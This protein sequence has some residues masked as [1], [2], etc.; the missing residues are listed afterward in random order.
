[1]AEV[2]YPFDTGGAVLEDQWRKM[3]RLWA[4][5]GVAADVDDQLEVF[6]DA[7]GLTVKVRTGS[8]WV[9]GHLFENTTQLTLNQP[10]GSPPHATL[11]RRD[12]IVLRADYVANGILVTWK[13]GVAAPTPVPPTLQQDSSVWEISLAVVAVAAAAPNIASGDFID[14]RTFS[15]RTGN[16]PVGIPVPQLHA[17]METG[18]VLADGRT[19]ANR[20]QFARLFAVWG[21]TFGAGD[22]VTTFG[23]PDLRG[24]TIVGL[25][26]MGGA[27]AG[28]LSVA[29]TI[30]VTG[31][32][33][34]VTLTTTQMAAHQHGGATATGG[35]GPTGDATANHV[36]SV[37][38]AAGQTGQYI[39]VASGAATHVVPTTA[40]QVPGA[41]DWGVNAAANSGLTSG[42]SVSH[43]HA[44]SAHSHTIPSEGAGA[45]HEN[46]PPFMLGLW[47]V[48]F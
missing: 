2:S 8:A 27:D 33:Q 24:R 25:D 43:A 36:H 30:G 34:T 32:Q 39:G 26:N 3:A 20:W 1:V 29:N 31:G 6:A 28:R 42:F 18:Y 40:N 15:R 17:T 22:G 14:T 10:G 21:T 19:N 44:Q 11:P 4:E 38:I 46:M 5:T 23:F 13:A 37:P 9:E 45:G 47:A 48:R 41:G 12:R 35:A 16:T 7:T